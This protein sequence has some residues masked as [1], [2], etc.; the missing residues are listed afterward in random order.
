MAGWSY[1]SFLF[2]SDL[3][4]LISTSPPLKKACDDLKPGKRYHYPVFV[5]VNFMLFNMTARRN[6]INTLNNMVL[7][8]RH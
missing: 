5:T 8:N 4:V 3:C 7:F 1:P 6:N 2:I